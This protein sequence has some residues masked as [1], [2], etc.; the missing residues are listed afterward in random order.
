MNERI[1]ND[2]FKKACEN[3]DLDSVIYLWLFGKSCVIVKKVIV[4]TS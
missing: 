2:N 1:L 4:S 3:G